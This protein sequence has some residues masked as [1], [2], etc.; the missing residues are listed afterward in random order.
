MTSRTEERRAAS[1]GPRG[2]SKGMCLSARVRLARTMRW[3][4]VGSGVRKAR[5]ISSV[6]RPPRRRRVRA[7]RDSVGRMGWQ[8]MKTRRRR[9]SPM[10]LSRAE[11]TAGEV[12][13]RTSS[14]RA[15]SSCLRVATAL[16][17]KR[18]MARRLAVAVSHAAGLSGTPD[19]GHSSSAATSA[20]C[21]RSSARPTSRVRRVSPAMTRADSMRQ[22]ASMV[23][24]RVVAWCGSVA[25]TAATDH[26]S[27]RSMDATAVRLFVC[28]LIWQTGPGLY[29]ALD[30]FFGQDGC[31]V[32][33]LEDLADF[34]FVVAPGVAV[35]ATLDPLD[36]LFEGLDLQDR[37]AGDELLGLGEGAVDDGTGLA[38]ESDACAFGAGME[39]IE[40]EQDASLHELFVVLAHLDQ[41]LWIGEGAFFFRLWGCFDDDHESHCEISFG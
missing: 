13:S 27:F 7:A 15:S 12:C 4:M 11:S 41:E 9:S 40:G 35:G 30:L 26:T 23:R 16:R 6:V 32:F 1:S 19:C 17:R 24:C 38:G 21:A 20:S 39:A 10:V 37:E 3:A 28:G 18:S 33:H 2:T 29:F 5:A 8:A 36:G 25:D 14:S 31:E 34:D 22:T